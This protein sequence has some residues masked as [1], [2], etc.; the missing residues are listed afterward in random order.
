MKG[1]HSNELKF[2]FLHAHSTGVRMKKR[3]LRSISATWQVAEILLDFVTIW[4]DVL[5]SQRTGDRFQNG[6]K[7]QTVAHLLPIEWHV[8][9][10]RSR[11]N[12]EQRLP[13]PD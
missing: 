13:G 2:S 7:Q 9:P 6:A 5:S 12:S 4:T 8:A 3:E 1:K 10:A 11:L